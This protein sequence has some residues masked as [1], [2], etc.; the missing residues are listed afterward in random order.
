MLALRTDNTLSIVQKTS[1]LVFIINVFQSLENE[2]VRGLALP[3]VSLPL[4]H[5][6]APDRLQVRSFARCMH[7]M[8]GL[9]R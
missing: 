8:C 2:M 1:Y 9:R 4:W 7:P 5:A 3:L 6:L